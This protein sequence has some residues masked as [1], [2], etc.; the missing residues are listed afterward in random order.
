MTDIISAEQALKQARRAS[1]RNHINEI[2]DL[3]E[4]ASDIGAMKVHYSGISHMAQER[5][6]T[7][8]EI[9]REAGYTVSDTDEYAIAI[10]IRWGD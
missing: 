3:I 7:I 2:N 8:K 1:V 4:N 6:D 10:E 5:V 9:L